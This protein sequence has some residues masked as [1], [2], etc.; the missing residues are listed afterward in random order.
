MCKDL[1]G[2]EGQGRRKIM[3]MNTPSAMSTIIDGKETIYQ[4]AQVIL[5]VR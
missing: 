1:G 2:Q 3:A 4:V 5:W